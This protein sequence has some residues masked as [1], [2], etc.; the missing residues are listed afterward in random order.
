MTANPRTPSRILAITAVV[1][2]AVVMKLMVILAPPDELI[3]S[4]LGMYEEMYRGV[5]ALEFIE[6]PV[7]PWMDYQINHF[8]GGSM[9][10]AVLA[11]PFFL[12]FGPSVIAMRLV[13]LLFSG[14]AVALL[15]AILDRFHGRRAAWVGSLLLAFCPPGYAIVSTT[16]WGTHLEGNT[17][18]LLLAFLF[19]RFHGASEQR[20]PAAFVLGVTGG[21]AIWFGYASIAIVGSLVVTELLFC[22]S[23]LRMHWYLWRSAGFLVGL[24]PWF[25]YNLTHDFAGFT[26]YG[27][28]VG[29]HIRE[30]SSGAEMLAVAWRFLSQDLPGSFYFTDWGALSGNVIEW[31]L[32]ALLL[33]LALIGFV[34]HLRKRSG[35]GSGVRPLTLG[36]VFTL[37]FLAAYIRSGFR[38]EQNAA[39]NFRYAMP[40]VPWLFMAVGVGVAALSRNKQ[41]TAKLATGIALAVGVTFTL[42]SIAMC[43]FGRAK[44]TWSNPGTSDIVLARTISMRY[45]RHPD[46]LERIAKNI[47]EK[48]PLERQHE[49]FFVL[50][51]NY[52]ISLDPK[53]K[54]KPAERPRE[55]YEPAIDRLHATVPE[56]FKPYFERP[57][58]REKFYGPFGRPQLERFWKDHKAGKKTRPAPRSAPKSKS[59]A[60]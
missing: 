34:T 37:V 49:L 48:R 55:H 10:M 28:S 44:S 60:E 15:F 9:V 11:V 42:G 45:S 47:L 58:P 56:A 50:G 57:L 13:T 39:Q 32:Y 17:L 14:L 8:S 3:P 46:Q 52:K 36:F 43:D 33:G 2:C 40:M 25:I 51:Q 53:T 4:G 6:G 35:S 26:M 59:D 21:F 19:L 23:H 41:K 22:R 27:Y 38:V 12:M 24:T 30:G 5:G 16:A 31:V 18:M 20:S 1:L 29:A 7:L 54:L